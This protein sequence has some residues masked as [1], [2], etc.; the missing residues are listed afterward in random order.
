MYGDTNYWKSIRKKTQL[1][2]LLIEINAFFNFE[3]YEYLFRPIVSSDQVPVA[4]EVG[5][6]GWMK[7]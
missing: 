5:H 2:L 1:I 4:D 6:G 7:Y 3:V